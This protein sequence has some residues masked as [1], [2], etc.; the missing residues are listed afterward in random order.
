[1]LQI[2]LF[3][4]HVYPFATQESLENN[5]CIRADDGSYRFQRMQQW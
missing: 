3:F 4:T 1:M 2:L 5:F